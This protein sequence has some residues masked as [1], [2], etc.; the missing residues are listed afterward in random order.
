M[1]KWWEP[2]TL[3]ESKRMSGT[4]WPLG[5][6]IAI[7]AAG[8]QLGMMIGAE[9]TTVFVLPEALTPGWFG[10]QV[11]TTS[12]F[13]LWWEFTEVAAMAGLLLMLLAFAIE[14][15]YRRIEWVNRL[16]EWMNRD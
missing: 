12:R 13:R 4:L 3:E 5:I 6:G 9:T 1:S 11:A 10:P 8:M 2:W 15:G 14:L 16:D 7:G